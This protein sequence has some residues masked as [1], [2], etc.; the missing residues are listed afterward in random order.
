MKTK[1]KEPLIVKC[2]ICE[3][4]TQRIGDEDYG[5]FWWCLNRPQYKVMK[6]LGEKVDNLCRHLGI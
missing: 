5:H 4:D 1:K 6:D 2:C 3:E